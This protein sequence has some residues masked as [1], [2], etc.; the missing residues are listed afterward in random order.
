M[1]GRNQAC[2]CGS[3]KKYKR[4]CL[5][6]EESNNDSPEI[7]TWRRVRRAIEGMAGRLFRF[8]ADQYGSDATE[9]AWQDFVFDSM[10]EGTEFDPQSVH[11]QIFM[12][13]F[14]HRWIPVDEDFSDQTITES[15]LEQ[16]GDDIDPLLV[17]YLQSCLDAPFS[18]HEIMRV[19]PGTG[20]DT[21]DV[22]SGVEHH[23]LEQSASRTMQ[24]GDILYGQLVRIQGI[25]LLEACAGCPIPPSR[26]ID[27]IDLRQDLEEEFGFLLGD[28]NDVM[29]DELRDLYFGMIDAVLNPPLPELQNTDGDPL[30]L[31]RL[32]FEVE[33]A[34]AA[35]DALHHLAIGHKP[36]ELLEDAV[37]SAQGML[38]SIE[39]PW[40]KAG[41]RKH[42][43]WS[44]TI[45]GHIEIEGTRLSVQVNSA[46]RAKTFKGILKK[47]LGKGVQLKAT[48]TQSTE[49]LLAEARSR[50]RVS[51]SADQREL[52]KNPQVQ[53]QLRAV[54]RAHFEDWVKMKLPALGGLTPLEAVKTSAGKEKV[55]ALVVEAERGA[56]RMEPAVDENILAHLRG[57]LGL[58]PWGDSASPKT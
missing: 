11:I 17:E 57:R 2:P 22:L 39:F 33:S 58:E 51:E 1:T 21:R 12:P 38:Q 46:K 26:K 41:N 40:S 8:A 30:E 44:N 47:T 18:F 55:A 34:Q 5:V 27:L 23:V 25:S 10:E 29:E 3:G 36:E 35:F 56:R 45:L 14:F 31:Q 16:R 43:S 24:V 7:L 9:L 42:P 53:E 52:Q 15:F 19:E 32:V 6:S 49:Q 4:C 50:P 48:E 54:M 37:Y 28:I 13:W 20:F